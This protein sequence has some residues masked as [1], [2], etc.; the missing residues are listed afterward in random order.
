MLVHYTN[1]L[2]E[3]IL[4]KTTLVPELLKPEGELPSPTELTMPSLYSIVKKFSHIKTTNFIAV[5]SL[6]PPKNNNN[7]KQNIQLKLAS[8]NMRHQKVRYSSIKAARVQGR[9]A[10]VHG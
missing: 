7:N 2:T 4:L 10:T 5:K 8:I 6:P 1:D 9:K 3:H